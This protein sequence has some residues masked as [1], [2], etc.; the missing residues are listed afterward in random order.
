MIVFSKA[1]DEHLHRVQVETLEE[2]ISI[3]GDVLQ[4]E[5]LELGTRNLCAPNG[6]LADETVCAAPLSDPLSLS[7]STFWQASLFYRYTSE[8]LTVGPLGPALD[9]QGRHRLGAMLAPRQLGPHGLWV[10]LRE[11]FQSNIA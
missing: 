10:S 6:Y 7:F 8:R 9:V 11:C 3:S 1:I 2:S 5:M 4:H